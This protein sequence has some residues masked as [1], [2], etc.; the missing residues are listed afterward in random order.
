MPYTSPEDGYVTV[1]QAAR[2]LRCSKRTVHKLC[3]SGELDC[4]RDEDTWY[5][6]M[7]VD[8]QSLAQMVTQRVEAAS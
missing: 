1:A 7:L 3:H 8:E 5:K 6:A 2:V 4:K